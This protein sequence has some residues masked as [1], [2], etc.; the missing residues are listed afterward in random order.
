[1]SWLQL[2]PESLASRAQGSPAPTLGASLRRGIVGFTLVSVAGFLPWGVFGKWFRGHGGE[3]AMYAVCALVFIVLSG[4]LL[5]RLIMGKGSLVRF[6]Q[7]FG[8]AFTAYSIAWIAG[9]MALRGHAGSLAGLFA[10][11][12]V[13]GWILSTA[14]AATGQTWKIIAALF[15]LNSTGYF[16]GGMIE[17]ALVKICECSGGVPLAKPT[18]MLL[19]KMQWGVCYG[20]GLGAGLGLA[21][22]LCQTRARALLRANTPAV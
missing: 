13:M 19:A 7:L 1:M 3:L 8:V 10:G 2:D 20:L 9:W 4:L 14:F 12:A 21:F 5:H 15:V 6:Y 17:E 22:W 11:T 18:Q 16:I